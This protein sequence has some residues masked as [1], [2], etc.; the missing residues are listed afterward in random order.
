MRETLPMWLWEHREQA[1]P[2]GLH[3]WKSQLP[4]QVCIELD[5]HESLLRILVE[6][7]ERVLDLVVDIVGA[8]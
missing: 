8:A 7:H 2:Y 1:G 6:T 3:I 4:T 5:I